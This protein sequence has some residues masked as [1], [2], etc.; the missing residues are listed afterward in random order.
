MTTPPFLAS[1]THAQEYIPTSQN[2]ELY[3]LNRTAELKQREQSQARE[4]ASLEATLATS[5]ND[6]EALDALKELAAAELRTA[7]GWGEMERHLVEMKAKYPTPQVFLVD[8]PTST[9]RE[10]IN[11]RLISLGLQQITQEQIRMTMIEELFHQDWTPPGA[12]KLSPSENE[13]VAEDNAN[14]LDSVWLRQQAH[15]EAIERWKEQEVERIADQKHGAPAR[16]AAPMPPK[17]IG[18]REQSR[19]TL[20]IDRM[21]TQSQRMRDLAAANMDFGRRNAILLVRMHVVGVR[22]FTPAMPLERDRLTRTLSEETVNAL[23][24]QVDDQSWLELVAY[25]DRLYKVDG[26]EEK[27]SDSPLGRSPLPSGSTEPSGDPAS[28]G[29]SSTESSSSPAQG[30]G[31]ATIIGMLSGSTSDSDA[32]PASPTAANDSPTADH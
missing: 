10:Q 14:F 22:G 17:I 6:E 24:E 26:G 25:I 9:Q 15:D 18:I 5:P 3:R 20:L 29:G 1:T 31:S 11:S 21:M 28:N 13:G 27:N 23:R 2:V 8:I 16:E 7:D 30:D 12:E 19:L 4:R 32:A